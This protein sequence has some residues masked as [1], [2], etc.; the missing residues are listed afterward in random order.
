[1]PDFGLE[2]EQAQAIAAY[3]LQAFPPAALSPVDPTAG[4][5]DT[6]KALVEEVGCLGCHSLESGGSAPPEVAGPNL[7]AIG[8]KTSAAWLFAWLKNPAKWDPQTAMPSLRLSDQEALDITVYLLSLKGETNEGPLASPDGGE[9]IKQGKAL[10]EEKGCFGCHRIPGFE[11]TERI[12]SAVSDWTVE[13]FVDLHQSQETEDHLVPRFQLKEGELRALAV[14]ANESRLPEG[15]EAE[16]AVGR[17][18]VRRYNC[19]GC[20]VLE[21]FEDGTAWGGDLC[22]HLEDEG[23]CP[24]PLDGEGMKVQSDWLVGYLNKV[25]PLRPW[26][27]VRMPSY[28]FAE[29]EARA[30]VAYFRARAGVG[31]EESEPVVGSERPVDLA[32]GNKLLEAFQCATCHP[33]DESELASMPDHSNLAPAFSLARIRLRYDRLDDWL[34]D[35]Q[36]MIPGTRMPDYFPDI[37]DRKNA[38]LAY[39]MLAAPH[40]GEIRKWFEDRFGETEMERRLEDSAWVIERLRESLWWAGEVPAR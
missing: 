21:R 1:M 23:L 24:P 11:E 13:D 25:T 32:V 33:A 28:S 19:T 30:L 8:S 12:G 10:I 34:L 22:A 29:G 5:I 18:L 37:G 40:N 7:S 35:P 20:H 26:L 6:G 16:I 4:D 31:R 3:L 36:G 14:A 38:S 39:N 9:R 27:K 15:T 17:L 2:V